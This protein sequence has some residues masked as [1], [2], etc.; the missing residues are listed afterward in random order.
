MTTHE[1][2][3]LPK[4][5]LDVAR[6]QKNFEIRKA[7]RDYKVG[8]VLL[9]REYD[10]GRYTGN[11]CFRTIEYIYKG[12][13]TFGLSEEFWVL[14]LETQKIKINMTGDNCTQIGYVGEMHC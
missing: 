12:D 5:F 13:G 4:W 3:I 2:K 7:D 8:D 11:Q 6:Y 14:G 10:R 9:L 1:L